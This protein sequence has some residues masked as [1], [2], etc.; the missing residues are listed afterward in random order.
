MNESSEV[1]LALQENSARRSEKS[2]RDNWGLSQFSCQ[3][4]WDCRLRGAESPVDTKIET[5][6]KT[7]VSCG[8]GWE[9]RLHIAVRCSAPA[10]ARTEFVTME[11]RYAR[12]HSNGSTSRGGIKPAVWMLLLGLTALAAT[13]G[14]VLVQRACCR[15]PAL[16]TATRKAAR[17]VRSPHHST[18]RQSASSVASIHRLCTGRQKPTYSSPTA[19]RNS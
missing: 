7:A 10:D 11:K 12:S 4:K 1:S 9:T 15:P 5:G 16:P 19:T 8:W 18:G 14:N 17:G 2:C 6:P 13:A 3:R